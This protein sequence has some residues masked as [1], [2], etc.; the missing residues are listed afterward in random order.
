M[1]I[2]SRVPTPKVQG[3][4][5]NIPL[6]VTE[7]ELMRNI[8]CLLDEQGVIKDAQVLDAKRL[9]LKNGD[10]SRA[11]RVTFGAVALPLLMRIN[12]VEYLVTPYVT[13][14]VRCYRCQAFGHVR[15]ACKAKS[16]VCVRCGLKGHTGDKCLSLI[17][18]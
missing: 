5:R 7:A 9:T 18:I 14:A 2:S 1:K 6:D 4:I 13:E 15:K 16:P 17:H 8:E 3:V 12:K 10:P 11:V